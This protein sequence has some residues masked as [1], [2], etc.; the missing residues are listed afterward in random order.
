MRR[1]RGILEALDEAERLDAVYEAGDRNRSDPHDGCELV[2]GHARLPFEP[3]DNHQLGPCHPVLARALVGKGADVARHF[4][5][6]GQ[7]ILLDSGT[8]L[9]KGLG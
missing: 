6:Q 2:L 5:Q 9:P 3:P 7:K 4:G 8:R 1:I